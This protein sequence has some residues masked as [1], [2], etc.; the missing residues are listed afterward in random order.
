MEEWH[1]RECHLIANNPHASSDCMEYCKLNTSAT[2]VKQ[3]VFVYILKT[4][5]AHMIHFPLLNFH[6]I[7]QELT[8]LLL[9]PNYFDFPAPKKAYNDILSIWKTHQGDKCIEDTRKKF[10]ESMSDRITQVSRSSPQYPEDYL[11]NKLLGKTIKEVFD[12]SVYEEDK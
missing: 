6:P 7:A 5:G 8:S 4:F 3:F 9:H 10:L 12:K 11:K 1:E 2:A